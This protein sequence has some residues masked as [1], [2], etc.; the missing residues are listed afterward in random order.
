MLKE[1][2]VDPGTVASDLMI[3]KAVGCVECKGRGY[4]GR[5]A[6]FETIV[7]NDELRDM[8]YKQIPTTEIKKVARKYG[9]RTLREDGWLKV[10]MGTTTIDEVRRSTAEEDYTNF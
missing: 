10:I 1:M 7:M 2:N 9:M 4:S 6:L 8:A 5:I 3:P